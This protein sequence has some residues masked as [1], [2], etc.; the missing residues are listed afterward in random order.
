MLHE[1][2]SRARGVLGQPANVFYVL[3]RDESLA[4][5]LRLGSFGDMYNVAIEDVATLA[6]P[7]LVAFK[8]RSPSDRGAIQAL[9]SCD[10]LVYDGRSEGGPCSDDAFVTRQ[11]QKRVG[12]NLSHPDF[13]TVDDRIPDAV[14]SA[15]ELLDK[16]TDGGS[17]SIDLEQIPTIVVGNLIKCPASGGD[18]LFVAKTIGFTE[19]QH[20]R[21]S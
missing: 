12:R 11:E 6:E 16:W 13:W 4:L 14:L 17:T 1:Y 8:R 10:M 9:R 15:S 7:T 5:A 19:Y 3:A 20:C 2:L 21:R 18:S